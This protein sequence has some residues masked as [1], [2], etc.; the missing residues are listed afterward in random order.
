MTIPIDVTHHNRLDMPTKHILV[1]DDVTLQQ[2]SM[3]IHLN[4]ILPYE[5]YVQTSFVPGAIMAAAI[6]ESTPV[7]LI[8][9][10]HD[11]PFGSGPELLK[12]LKTNK[13]NIPVITFSGIPSNNDHLIN[14]GA[15]HKFQKNEVISGSADNIIM[16]ILK[17]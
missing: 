10:D 7:D 8:I 1:C 15:T 17:R 5:G 6:I 14:L 12:W 11:M 9:L 4:N 13:Y 2:V 16:D 3:A